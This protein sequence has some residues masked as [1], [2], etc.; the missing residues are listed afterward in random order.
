MLDEFIANE[1]IFTYIVLFSLA[2]FVISPVVGVITALLLPR[3]ILQDTKTNFQFSTRSLLVWLLRNLLA[4]ILLL[5]GVIM[6]F[7][8]GQGVLTIL[9]GIL[10][11]D[12]PY[13]RRLQKR[14]LRRPKIL[15]SLNKLRHKF[16]VAPLLAPD[17]RELSK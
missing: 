8:P 15:L 16:G 3:D 10:I 6:L 7:I 5:A 1:N 13:K 9:M 12:F 4:A 17:K 14:I 11:A 2:L